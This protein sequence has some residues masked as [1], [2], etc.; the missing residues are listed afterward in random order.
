MMTPFKQVGKKA[1]SLRDAQMHNAGFAQGA[2]AAAAAVATEEASEAVADTAIESAAPIDVQ[3]QRSARSRII[4]GN[5]IDEKDYE[6]ACKQKEGHIKHYGDDS[7]AIYHLQ[8]APAPVIGQRLGVRQ[9]SLAS[10]NAALDF[11]RDVQAAGPAPVTAR[12]VAD[13]QGAPVVIGNI[14]MGFGHYR[15]GMAMASAARAMGYT[16]YW[17][18]LCGF[19]GTTA[20]KLVQGQNKLYS[21]GSRLSQKVAPFNTL[22]WEP[23]NSEGF[24]QLSYNAGDQ[25]NAELFVPVYRDLPLDIPFVATHAWPAQGAIHA[26]LTRVVNA[27]P[28]NWPMALHLA[29]GSVHAVQ[30]PGAALG[31]QML[32][33]MSDKPLCPM[34]PGSVIECGHYIDHELVSNIEA[35][36]QARLQ[37]ASAGEPV[38]YLICVGGAGAQKDYIR[39]LIRYLMRYVQAGEAT[40]LINVG[41]HAKVWRQLKQNIPDLRAA[42]EHFNNFD[43]VEAFA[44]AAQTGTIEG[45]HAF[46]DK[47]IFSAV[48][49]TNVLMRACDVLVTKPSELAYYPV[50]KMMIRRVGGHEAWGAIRAAELGDGTYELETVTDACAMA[51]AIQTDRGI[52]VDMGNHIV[53]A[54]ACGVYDGAYKVIELATR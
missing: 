33:G 44:A 13:A 11:K 26:G 20:T 38:R 24:R 1:Q 43:E 19:P 52:I 17:F 15:I 29:E 47:D 41:D 4:F 37:R 23:L 34:P 8:A 49:S 32:R 46:C 18:D 28:D 50:P 51:D 6:R 2:P 25:M 30:T 22:Y 42:V 36:T 35:N 12:T 39:D 14:R 45:I 16:P 9:L 21:M 7:E 10:K 53:S 48:Y 5:V 54:A 27:I 40:L 3:A 31:Y